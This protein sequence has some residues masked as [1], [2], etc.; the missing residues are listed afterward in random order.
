MP[1]DCIILYIIYYLYVNGSPWLWNLDLG[2][3]MGNKYLSF[4]LDFKQA[5]F[6]FKKFTCLI[7]LVKTEL[8]RN[9]DFHNEARDTGHQA[10]VR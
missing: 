1:A 9:R 5:N 7:L 4:K 8:W 3:S 10:L 2:L 6:F